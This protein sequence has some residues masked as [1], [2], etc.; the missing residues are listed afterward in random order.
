MAPLPLRE[1]ES[2]VAVC[3]F[4]GTENWLDKRPPAPPKPHAPPASEPPRLSESPA[5]RPPA[6]VG[7]PSSGGG[8]WFVLAVIGAVIAGGIY[9]AARRPGMAVDRLASAPDEN[10]GWIQISTAAPVGGFANFD[11][12]ANVPWAQRIGRS[13]AKDALLTSFRADAVR[14][15]GTADLATDTGD[16]NDFSRGVWYTF[17]SPSRIA[18]YHRNATHREHKVNFELMIQVENKRVR[19]LRRVDTPGDDLIPSSPLPHICSIGQ[20]IATLLRTHRIPERP[21]YSATF[22][23]ENHGQSYGFYVSTRDNHGS[24]GVRADNCEPR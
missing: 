8:G 1:A 23:P 17:V 12:V 20:A 14:R 21:V 11:P 9:F 15:N 18:S 22:N 2:G 19:V 10:E 24:G 4:C 5:T 7:E 16:E 13:W 6:S 3:R